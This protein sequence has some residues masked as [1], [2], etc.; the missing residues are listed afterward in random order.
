MKNY[1]GIDL[2][3]TNSVIASCDGITPQT[4][5]S[6]EQ[7][8]ITPSA[9]YIDKRGAKYMGLRA[10]SMSLREPENSAVLFKR[11]MGTNTLIRFSGADV[12]KKPEECSAEIL[13]A[14]YGYLPGEIRNDDET[15]TVI[16]VPAAFNQMQKN[17]TADA[18]NMAGIGRV[19]LMQEPVAAVMSVMRARKNDGMFLIY[20]LGGGTLDIAVAE[21]IGGRVNLLAHGGIAMCG[22]RDFD[23]AIFDAVVRPWL[24]SHFS[25]PEEF[26]TDPHF[27]TLTRWA[28]SASENAKIALS[29]VRE[30][31][32]SLSAADVPTPILDRGKK[33][34]YFDIPLR[35]EVYEKLTEDK[36]TSSI[37]AA[38]DTLSNAGLKPGD[39][40]CVVFIGGPTNYE[41]LRE[42]VA[43]EL[44]IRV[45]SGVNPM[46]AVAE[47]ASMFAES[48]DWGAA[49]RSR[50]KL[51]GHIDSSER[52]NLSF[53]FN[54]RT[55]ESRAKIVARVTE[56]PRGYE[57]QADSVDTGWT[58]GR[59]QLSDG[60]SLEL[61]LPLEGDNR[62]RI[63]VFDAKG[64]RV[65]LENDCAV[66]TRTAATVG[67]IPASH[68]VAVE[69]LEKLGGKPTLEY[70]VRKG[71]ALPLKGRKTFKA[72]ESLAAGS[73]DTLNFKLWEGEI[74]DPIADNRSI[75]VFKI[76]GL[77]FD[78]G[79]IPTGADLECEYE[80][81]D[82]GHIDVRFNVPS[83]GGAFHSDKNFYSRQ[84]GQVDYSVSA[85]NIVSDGRKTL[86]RIYEL[87]L[88]IDDPRLAEARDKM[89]AL[90]SM[91]VS[92]S[93]PEKIQ[94]ADEDIRAAR[95]LLSKVREEHLSEL[96]ILDLDKVA[97]TFE[98]TL[99]K[100]A[101][102]AETADFDNLAA[103]A[104]RSVDRDDSDFEQYL[105]RLESMN[106]AVQ[107]RQD[108]YI[109]EVFKRWTGIP[110]I[111]SDR[112]RF[113]ELVA[114]GERFVA[115]NRAENLRDVMM[116]LLKLIP[117]V[118]P[119]ASIADVTNIIRG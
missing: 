6:P 87:K 53:N 33:E 114:Q 109:E 25:L 77:D 12:T 108:W 36:I 95:Q 24:V 17:A 41:P 3:T 42:R 62:F 14:L 16:T 92:A 119:D 59:V 83:I 56:A 43:S 32:I 80:I 94:G 118:G 34:I 30:S 65:N 9:I 15:G 47:G 104:R 113:D 27:K 89:E 22:G 2:G 49:S 103:V 66:I 69:V 81:L 96:R 90:V 86:S 64:G 40:E 38:R 78:G 116:E 85:G 1:V 44:G 54:A 46:T 111:F 8:D 67:A 58:S 7:N 107:W 51:R 37:N 10:Y 5:K 72:A 70:L 106:F 28:I 98:N 11:L 74:K 29:T 63:S 112:R 68:S 21:S 102:P 35:R 71:D 19:A 93:D 61:K 110:Q 26:Q 31:T 117:G 4:W 57:F 88:A 52:L 73:S 84:E 20:D 100:Y 105:G 55:P 50:K 18:A 91:D 101:T 48:I 97:A 60:A 39:I 79:I 13:K 75:G 23:R 99:R 82:S 76:S 45:S 115:E